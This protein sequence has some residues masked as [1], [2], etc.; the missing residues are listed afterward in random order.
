M[1]L[2]TLSANDG[3]Q[4]AKYL[5]LMPFSQIKAPQIFFPCSVLCHLTIQ[6]IILRSR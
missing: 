6:G 4:C 2:H 3:L 5:T 1:G